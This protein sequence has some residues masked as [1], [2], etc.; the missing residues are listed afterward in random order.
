MRFI[1]LLPAVLLASCMTVP[2]N[3][4]VHPEKYNCDLIIPTIW[5]GEYPVD[6]F[7]HEI[8]LG[9]TYYDY[10]GMKYELVKSDV[11]SVFILRVRLV[12]P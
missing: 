7:E 12:K 1:Y 4:Y 9:A 6:Y 11:D 2:Q 8:L 5:D 3:V 10:L